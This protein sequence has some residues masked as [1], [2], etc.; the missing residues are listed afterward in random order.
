[1]PTRHRRKAQFSTR[2]STHPAKQ[3]CA[4]CC[5]TDGEKPNKGTARCS[6]QVDLGKNAAFSN[7]RFSIQSTFPH[8]TTHITWVSYFTPLA[9]RAWCRSLTRLTLVHR[10]T[11]A[12]EEKSTQFLH[13]NHKIFFTYDNAVMWSFLRWEFEYI[14]YFPD[15]PCLWTSGLLN[16]TTAWHHQ[17]QSSSSSLTFQIETR[18]KTSV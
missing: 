15:R 6:V 1:M 8:H 10:V 14:Q 2:G 16:I 11:D 12:L 17:H 18:E 13:C 5:S 3:C 7:Q 4:P 9:S